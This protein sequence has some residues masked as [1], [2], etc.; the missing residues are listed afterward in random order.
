MSLAASTDVIIQEEQVAT[1]TEVVVIGGGVIGC[2]TAVQLA[3]KGVKRVTLLEKGAQVAVGA[4]G[5]SGGLVRMHYTVPADACLAWRSLQLWQHWTDWATAASPFVNSG[6]VQLVGPTDVEN[7]KANVNMLRGL[8]IDT[9]MITQEELKELA[10][11]MNVSDVGGA[12]YEPQ[13]GYA[14]PVDATQELARRAT[15]LGVDVRLN[16]GALR[17]LTQSGRVSGVETDSGALHAETVVLAAGAWSGKLAQSAGV[18]LRLTAKR[19]MAGNVGWPSGLERHPVIIDRASGLYTRNDRNGRNLFGLEPTLL[20]DPDAADAFEVIAGS[21]EIDLSKLAKRLPRLS[22]GVEPVGWAAPDAYGEDY[23]AILGRAPGVDRLFLATGG[24]GSNFKTAPA[25]GE[26]IAE[27][28]VVG[29]TQHVDLEPFRASRFDEGKP[30]VG[31]H[32]YAGH[33][34]GHDIERPGH[35]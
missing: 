33:M 1:T 8:G 18:H 29:R 7:L 26:A 3:L 13:S 24:S 23:H 2:A 11:G 27:L 35:G 19:V 14:Y 34:I 31:A 6:F 12:A 16:T 32:E 20:V 9:S 15:E 22:Q 4:S 25:I 5:A 28:V 30:L 17:I 10:P 21:L